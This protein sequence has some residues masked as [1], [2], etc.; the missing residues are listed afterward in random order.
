MLFQNELWKEMHVNGYF[1]LVSDCT[2]TTY[3]I[4]FCSVVERSST[5]MGC[6]R[7]EDG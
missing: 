5:Q 2:F 3:F 1:Q 4:L 7:L 6:K